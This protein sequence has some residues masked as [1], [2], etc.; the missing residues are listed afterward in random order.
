MN[1][2]NTEQNKEW[3]LKASREK[4]QVTHKVR[5]ITIA[6]DTSV[7][8]LKARRTWTDAVQVIKDHR[9]QQNYQSQ[10]EGQR[11][12]CHDEN[13]FRELMSSKPALWESLE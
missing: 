8:I 2:Q 3:I 4:E 6:P 5:F 11:K 7:G 10:L 12:T 1:N 9:C 13:R